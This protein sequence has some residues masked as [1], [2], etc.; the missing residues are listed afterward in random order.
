MECKASN[1]PVHVL[2]REF[3]PKRLLELSRPPGRLYFRGNLPDFDKSWI[4]M[5]GTRRPS[6]H[7]E[8][9]CERLVANLR[10]TDAIVVSGLAQGIDS[11]CHMQA[12]RSH[13]PTVAVIAQ[14]IEADI[15]G[16]R[17]IIARQIL[18]DGGAILS[19]YPERI[20]SQKFM[21]PERNRIIAGLCKS[22]TLIESR[23]SGGGMLTVRYAQ[24][25]K[26]PVLCVPGNIL[27]STSEGPNRCIAKREAVPVWRPEDFPDLCGAKRLSDPTP[28]DLFR[29]GIRIENDAWTLFRKCAG[30]THTL[31]TLRQ[32]SGISISRLLAI[33]TELEIA[34]LVHSKDGNEFH[35]LTAG[36]S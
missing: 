30:F 28:E 18:H 11:F 33:L 6:P 1:F 3:F 19:E 29:A 8:G 10:G 4:A 14:G 31:E 16:S 7:A 2:E 13:I 9:I 20:P 21:F 12:I 25:L 26:R 36:S 32:D 15:G 17:G 35:F 24:G 34:G 22:A 5:V 23:E 27:A